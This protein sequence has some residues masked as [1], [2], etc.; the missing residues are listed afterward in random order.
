MNKK[1]LIAAGD[2]F[3][4]GH[5]IGETASWAY[6][7]SD[8]LGLKL[9]NLADGG[10]S[11]ELISL[12]TLTYLL[13]N[14]DVLNNCIVMIG[15][16]EMSRQLLFFD[17]LGLEDIG[18]WVWSARPTDFLYN[19][20]DKISPGYWLYKNKNALYPFFSNLAWA[21]SKT[22]TSILNLKTFLDTNNINYIF[23]DV[24]NNNKLF[25]DDNNLPY[26]K[27]FRDHGSFN[28]PNNKKYD[29][30]GLNDHEIIT[31]ILTKNTINYI[32]DKTYI[33]F[34]ENYSTLLDWLLISDNKNVFTNKYLIGNDGHSN[35]HG[36]KKAAKFIVNEY[37][38]I[39]FYT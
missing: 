1:Y 22:Y 27:N 28:F 19:D 38:K 14:K 18:K 30:I 4:T 13:N 12:K 21:L 8:Q 25:F 10:S 39:Y 35:M 17:D 15:W 16:S 7:V 33:S 9:I 6:W 26:L 37:K 36:A 32:F 11:N 23:F 20:H 5:S 34:D 24:I 29:F 31:H 2:S 3:T